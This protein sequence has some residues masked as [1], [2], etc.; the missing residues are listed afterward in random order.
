MKVETSQI[1]HIVINLTPDDLKRA[2]LDFVAKVYCGHGVGEGFDVGLDRRRKVSADCAGRGVYRYGGQIERVSLIP[3]PQAPD[4][5]A[6]R[7][8]A[9]AQWD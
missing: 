6:N 4:S 7:P 5:F 3:G 8:E 1:N 2:V 9:M